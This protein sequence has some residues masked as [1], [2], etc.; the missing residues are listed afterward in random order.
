MSDALTLSARCIRIS[1][2]QTDALLTA[3]LLPVML[4][5][6]FVELFGGAIN[7]GQPHYVTYVVPGVLV[8]CAGFGAATTGVAVSHDMTGGIVD[9]LRSMD[10]SGTAVITGHITASVLRNAASTLLVLAV[11]LALGFHPHA[12]P[13]DALAAAGVLVA[14]VLAISAL[15]AALGL[16][17]STPEAAN[18]VTFVIMFLPYA[19]S[20]FVPI[21]TMP[22]WLQGFAAHQPITPV[23]DTLR[24]LLLGTPTTGAGTALAWCAGILA[25]S[26]AVS[27][28][29]FRRRTA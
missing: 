13:L 18:G 26:M 6:V 27:A 16:L 24:G 11:A 23:I 22:G 10:I 2:R 19:S 12:G 17:A 4:M 14:F 20:A 15:A 1:M 28:T 3:L 7:T 29:L 5:L 9:R 21:A 8:L 25:L